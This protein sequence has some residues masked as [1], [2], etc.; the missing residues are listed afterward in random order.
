MQVT[1]PVCGMSIDSAKAAAQEAVAGQTYYFCS[2]SCHSK[3]R[4][5]PARYTAKE[6]GGKGH[7]SHRCC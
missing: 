6:H 5:D 4:A 2:D 7:G 3:F 1:D